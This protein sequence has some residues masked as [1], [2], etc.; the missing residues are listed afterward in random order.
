MNQ[1]F[2]Q[3]QM[4]RRS[5]VRFASILLI[6]SAMM[7]PRWAAAQSIK[8]NVHGV[9]SGQELTGLSLADALQGVQL[10]TISEISV[11]EGNFTAED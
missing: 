7:L 11:L 4:H 8:I 6:V 9:K 5:L 10:D 3:K 2:T 1:I